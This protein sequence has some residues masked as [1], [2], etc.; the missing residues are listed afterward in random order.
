MHVTAIDLGAS[1]GKLSNV[2]YDGS[3]LRVS[4][5][6]RFKNEPIELGGHLYNDHDYMLCEIKKGIVSAAS[7]DGVPT[8]IGLDSWGNDYALLDKHGALIS[9]S[10]NYRDKRT[11]EAPPKPLSEART[12][13]LTGIPSVPTN[14]YTQLRTDIAKM[15]ESEIENIGSFMMFPDFLSY[16]LS[17]VIN[18]EITVAST[19]A[20]ANAQTCNWDS[21]V[22]ESMDLRRDIF[23]QIVQP[24][25]IIGNLSDANLKTAC[26]S[27]VKFIKPACHDTGSAVHTL[28]DIDET[29]I[30][31]SL[32]SMA[33]MGLIS[34]GPIINKMTFDGSFHNQA[35]GEGKFRVQ[36]SIQGLWILSQCVRA[37]QTENSAIDFGIVE[38]VARESKTH[39][40][41]INVQD[42]EFSGIGNM[43]A[44][45]REYCAVTG[46]QAPQD[47]GEL[48]RCVY[49]SLTIQIA[50]TAKELDAI[51]GQKHRSIYV[52]GGGSK[53]RFLLSLIAEATG[54]TVV[55][56]LD[57]ASTTGNALLQLTALGE[58][59]SAGE[60]REL[61]N[62]SFRKE[63]IAVTA[64]ES[65]QYAEEKASKVDA[66]TDWRKR[67]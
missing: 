62:R 31:I 50:R 48:A 5:K 60:A 35:L 19:S 61:L 67:R 29:S 4:E 38:N 23:P 58:I 46:Q 26:L 47:I 42:Q 30:Y 13:E 22:I 57:H 45:I 24:G 36:K 3:K 41:Y 14:T 64:N 40:F 32:G 49:E 8:A 11:I 2:F 66:M 25:S 6:Y 20:L 18:S 9:K 28:Q 43:P 59:G 52:V 37:W 63:E 34:D 15:T 39:N 7:E 27:N 12:Y 55:S 16:M 54:K 65:W 10:Y 51:R 1:S 21:E 17:G 53:D 33:L 56:T 44:R